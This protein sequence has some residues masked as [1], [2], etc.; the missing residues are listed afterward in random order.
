MKNLYK[1]HLYSIIFVIAISLLVIG[2]NEQNITPNS[3]DIISGRIMDE[4]GI[5]IPNASVEVVSYPTVI[6]QEKEIQSENII[7]FTVT[8]ED[9]FFE[10]KNIPKE[11]TGLFFRVKHK[12]FKYFED[13]LKNILRNQDKKKVPIKLLCNDSCCGRVEITVLKKSDSTALKEVEIKVRRSNELVKKSYTNSDGKLILERICPSEY[14]LRLAKTGYKVIEEDFTIKECDTIHYTFYMEQSEQS[15][16]TCC[17]GVII[18]KFKNSENQNVS[19]VKVRLWKEG[20]KIREELTNDDGVVTFREICKGKFAISAYKQ[21]Y[22]EQEFQ[23]EM[24]CND[25]NE[26]IK[27][28]QAKE[29]DTCCNGIIKVYPRDASNNPINGIYLKIYKDGVFL[30]QVKSVNGYAIFNELCSGRYQVDIKTDLYK[31]LE[32]IVELGCNDT[33]IVEKYLEKKDVD[34]CCNGKIIIYFKDS[35]SNDALKNVEVKLYKGSNKVGIQTSD[36]NGKVVFNNICPGEYRIVANREL[37]YGLEYSFEL[38]CND[39]KEIVKKML[40]KESID[41][42]CNAKLKIKVVDS[43]ETAIQNATVKLYAGGS[44]IKTISTN[45]E[46]Y[47]IFENLCIPP[48]KYVVEVIKEDYQAVEYAIEYKECT[49]IQKTIMLKQ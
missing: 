30:K 15:E 4:Q 48:Y 24:G 22:E 43:T 37:Y 46:G 23:I 34:T 6:K 27:T 11:L 33:A 39:T 41:T 31:P 13:E 26:V 18:V 8:D 2:C 47:A 9:G 45:V 40:K 32:F 14:N 42:C 7:S 38:G 25:T 3:D 17:K 36:D 1:I 16:D 28:L 12:D 44:L 5:G 10:L 19:G 29:V 21:G 49:T 35:T 20:T